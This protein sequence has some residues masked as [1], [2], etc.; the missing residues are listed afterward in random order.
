MTFITKISEGVYMVN[1]KEV[2]TRLP[3]YGKNLKASE[4][5]SLLNYIKALEY[6]KS[7]EV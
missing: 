1:G 6:E 2:D 3:K 5:R 4:Y 7:R